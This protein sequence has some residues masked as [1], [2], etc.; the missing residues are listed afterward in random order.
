MEQTLLYEII[1][2]VY[3][4]RLLF[5]DL[6]THFQM[7]FQIVEDNRRPMKGHLTK[8][9]NGIPLEIMDKPAL[10]AYSKMLEEFVLRLHHGRNESRNSPRFPN[11]SKTRLKQI[12][13]DKK[14]MGNAGITR[15]TI[16]LKKRERKCKYCSR[17]HEFGN[18]N[19]FAQGK[20][21][22]FCGKRYHVIE[23][24]WNKKKGFSKPNLS[25]S[26]EFS[27]LVNDEKIGESSIL[28]R[29]PSTQPLVEDYDAKQEKDESK[30][31]QKT[32]TDSAVFDKELF[33]SERDVVCNL[34]DHKV[35]KKRKSKKP[36]D[37]KKWDRNSSSTMVHQQVCSD[38]DL[39]G[40]TDGQSTSVDTSRLKCGKEIA[41]KQISLTEQ[42]QG[43]RDCQVSGLTEIQQVKVV[44]A[45]NF[46]KLCV[47]D[48]NGKAISHIVKTLNI[49]EEPLEAVDLIADFNNGK[50]PAVVNLT[51]KR[52]REMQTRLLKWQTN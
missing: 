3:L 49:L 50:L 1:K 4:Y 28:A 51:C 11:T 34:L 7:V 18:G 27:P 21:C 39:Y 33:G 24:C 25:S 30:T 35:S 31:L 5:R 42:K 44:F 10:T 48:D 9:S 17:I 20:T 36:R 2:Y 52:E 8:F 26:R 29:N 16:S 46:R 13:P 37:Y 15:K 6:L 22:S 45:N 38:L 23:A 47:F 32:T 43:N 19:C 41:D 40:V 14:V 12:S